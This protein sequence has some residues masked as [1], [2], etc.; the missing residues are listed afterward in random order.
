[1]SSFFPI[2][3]LERYGKKI[4]NLEVSI[5]LGAFEFA[6][7]LT[8][9]FHPFIINKLGKKSCIVSCYIALTICPIILSLLYRC[10]PKGT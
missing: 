10:D 3:V 6:G 1:M 8:A 7:I 4:N 9:F 5:M 2:F